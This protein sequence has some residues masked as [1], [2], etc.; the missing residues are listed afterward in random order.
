MMVFLWIGSRIGFGWALGIAL[1]T[2]ILGSYLV[3]RAGMAVWRRFRRRLDHGELPGRE[4]VHGAAILVA[5]ALLISPG[6]MTDIAGFLLLV[7]AVRDLAYRK[8]SSR[9]SSRVNVFSMGRSASGPVIDV[10]E[11]D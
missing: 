7:P 6:F 11:I 9:L 3:R 2:A 4:M 10:D 8:L 1:V 5:G